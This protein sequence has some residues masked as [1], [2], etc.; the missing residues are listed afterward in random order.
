MRIK[1]DKH[2]VQL[3]E[4]T[5]QAV[6]PCEQHNHHDSVLNGRGIDGATAARNDITISLPDLQNVAELKANDSFSTG[7][8]DNK[9]DNWWSNAPSASAGGAVELARKKEV[10]ARPVR[11]EPA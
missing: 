3:K 10:A 7:S 6:A 11:S 1:I 9:C 5:A 8:S 2:R 4:M